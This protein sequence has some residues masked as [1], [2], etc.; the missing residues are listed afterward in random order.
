MNKTDR[1]EM[2]SLK[3]QLTSLDKKM[4]RLHDALLDDTRTDRKGVISTVEHMKR[5]MDILMGAYYKAKWLI[6]ILT[7]MFLALFGQIVKLYWFND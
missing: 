3:D 5:D 6:G 7:S 4:T 2:S 1:E